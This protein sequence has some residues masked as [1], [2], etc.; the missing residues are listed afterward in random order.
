ME[1]W[2]AETAE[3]THPGDCAC[4][5][6]LLELAADY[7]RA[8]HALEKLRRADKSVPFD[9]IR[10]VAIHATELHLHAFLRAQG[11]EGKEIRKLNHD[12][13]RMTALAAQKGIVLRGR[14]AAHLQSMTGAREYRNVRYAP[15]LQPKSS[16]INRILAT[17]EEVATKVAKRLEPVGKQKAAA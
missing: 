13:A 14:T 17:L 7:R 1:G 12:L 10:L 9:P 8:A 2:M 15:Q 4:V 11:I 5:Q 3:M 6:A 16:Q